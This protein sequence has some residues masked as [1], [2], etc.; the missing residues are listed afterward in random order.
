MTT[1]M[2]VP[3]KV[4]VALSIVAASFS[5]S[6][7]SAP[8]TAVAALA[9]AMSC[10]GMTKPEKVLEGLQREGFIGEVPVDFTDGMPTYR[11][12]KPLRILGLNVEYVKG[13]D[14]AGR[15]FSR[16]P[17]TAPGVWIEVVVTGD[18]ANTEMRISKALRRIG[19]NY[20]G[21]PG[22][23]PWIPN[24]IR[25]MR[26]YTKQANLTEINCTPEDLGK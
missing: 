5:P 3:T 14:Y 10:R 16:G 15:L 4:A 11:V 21:D 13:W 17:G 6:A 12:L 22:S 1:A 19:A 9:K 20:D 18:K 7:V 2:K 24:D 23:G 25:E 8:S 26:R